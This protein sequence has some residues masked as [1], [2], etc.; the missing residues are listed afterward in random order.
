MSVLGPMRSRGW[1]ST[2]A[3]TDDVYRVHENR[4][5]RKLRNGLCLAPPGWRH[6]ASGP[7]LETRDHQYYGALPETRHLQYV[8]FNIFQPLCSPL[9]PGWTPPARLQ[10]NQRLFLTPGHRLVGTGPCVGAIKLLA[11]VDVYREICSVSLGRQR[12]KSNKT[13]IMCCKTL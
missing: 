3:P 8:T 11:R 2:W 10:H 1:N 7:P 12:Q 13:I 5:E 9:L 6:G 4:R